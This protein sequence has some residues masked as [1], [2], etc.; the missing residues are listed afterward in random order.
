MCPVRKMRKDFLPLFKPVIGDEEIKEV[1]AILKS[2]WLTTGPKTR[3]FEEK[4]AEYSGAKHGIGVINCTAALFMCLEVAKIEKGSEVIT[5]PLTWCSSANVIEN[6]GLNTVFADVNKLTGCIDP[7][8][9]E[10]NITKKTKAIIPV[11]FAGQPC[12]MD[13]ILKLAERHNLVVVED[14][15]HAIGAS[16]KNRKIGSISRFTCFSFYANKNLTTGQG[17]MITANNDD[18]ARI[19]KMMRMYGLREGAEDRYNE[20]TISHYL[21]EFPGYN[22]R[23]FDLLAAIGM[24]QLKKFEDLNAKR[25]R[26]MDAYNKAFSGMEHVSIYGTEGY[27]TSH[28]LHMYSI[29]VDIDNL[30]ITRDNFINEL[31]SRNI[32]TGLHYDALH[33]HPFYQKKYGLK[34]GDFPNTEYLSDRTISLP[35]FPSMTK[36]DIDDVISAVKE[37]IGKFKK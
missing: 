21:V 23:M 28:G 36:E 14:A 32:G 1:T 12:D 33:L 26:I 6:A 20:K 35:F 4:F 8:E 11:H 5:T 7:K 2:G 27:T 29:L 13:P 19:L 25:K 31:R 10:K 34:R 30:K 3:E 24:P 37:I 22:F 17:G 16:Y 15:A 18:D 9:I